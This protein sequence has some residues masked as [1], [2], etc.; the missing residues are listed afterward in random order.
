MHRT[1]QY[2]SFSYR[3][4]Q[5]AVS[6]S[7]NGMHGLIL[8]GSMPEKG[9]PMKPVEMSINDLC[10]SS[11]LVSLLVSTYRL[12]NERNFYIVLFGIR[13]CFHFFFDGIL[14]LL[15]WGLLSRIH[16]SKSA[17][18]WA[19]RWIITNQYFIHALNSILMS[20]TKRG[21]MCTPS[22]EIC[23]WVI[24]TKMGTN[25]GSKSMLCTNVSLT[26]GASEA[27]D[28]VQGAIQ[29]PAYDSRLC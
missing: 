22:L 16:V 23:V 8:V 20:A 24:N 10:W 25:L 27:N 21:P 14:K 26:M 5:I 29:C 18:C 28:S 3:A 13:S 19:C 9:C 11:D 12:G 1:W 17:P 2:I 4:K 6:S 7:I 15:I